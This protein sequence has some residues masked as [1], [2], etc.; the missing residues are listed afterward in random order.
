M[1]KRFSKS[2]SKTLSGKYS[3]KP[4]DHAKQSPVDALKPT[5][6]RLIQKTSEATGDVIGNI[7]ANKIT[8]ILNI[9]HRIIQSH[10]K[11]KKKN[12]GFNEEIPK[13]RYI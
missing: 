9:P 2:I 3:Q 6:K 5:S 11:M 4:L 1:D 7:I 13:E 12:A 10:L 8:K